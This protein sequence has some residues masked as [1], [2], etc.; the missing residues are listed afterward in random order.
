[1]LQALFCMALIQVILCGLLFDEM[2]MM[3]GLAYYTDKTGDSEQI[4]LSLSH[5]VKEVILPGTNCLH[6]HGHRHT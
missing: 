1:M 2:A 3:S 4:K 6:Y 5:I